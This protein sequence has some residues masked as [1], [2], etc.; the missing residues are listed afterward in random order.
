MPI[1]EATGESMRRVTYG[2][3]SD[4]AGSPPR[5]HRP[6]EFDLMALAHVHAIAPD[7]KGFTLS[8]RVSWEFRANLVRFFQPCEAPGADKPQYLKA[9]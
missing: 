7:G 5:P 1:Y 9:D 4:D 6:A 8:A 3:P 2:I